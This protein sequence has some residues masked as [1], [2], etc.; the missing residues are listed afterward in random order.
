MFAIHPDPERVVEIRDAIFDLIT[1]GTI[2]RN[3]GGFVGTGLAV[4]P[5]GHT[6]F[7]EIAFAPELLLGA[8]PV[9]QPNT[10]PI[11]VGRAVSHDAGICLIQEDPPDH[12]DSLIGCPVREC[13]GRSIE[14]RD[15]DSIDDD[16]CG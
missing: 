16:A 1:L 3:S 6:P 2:D 13:L 14:S 7:N 10:R 5:I 8:L 4:V 11:E 9:V 12:L 15:R